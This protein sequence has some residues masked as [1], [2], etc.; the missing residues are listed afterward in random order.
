MRKDRA[1]SPPP[2]A[3]FIISIVARSE[4][5]RTVAG[6]MDEWYSEIARLEGA[7][8][9]SRWYWGQVAAALPEF[10]RLSFYWRTV[11]LKN[12]LRSAGRDLRRQKMFSL[13][14]I[15]GLAVGL[16]CVWLI[17]LY[18]RFETSFDRFHADA[19]RIYRVVIED[20]QNTYQK[21]NKFAVT[22]APL[23]P[24][25]ER[26]CP[27]VAAGTR[28]ANSSRKL[29][30][31]GERSFYEDG[32]HG[33]ENFF[34]MFSFPLVRGEADRSLAEPNTIVISERL[35]RKLFGTDDSL[36]RTVNEEGTTDY[37]VTGVF[38]DVPENSH[39]QFDFVTSFVTLGAGGRRSM[40]RWDE[41]S[42]FTY[43]KLRPETSPGAFTEKMRAV[44]SA[45]AGEEEAAT[46]TPFLLPL[47]GVH[48]ATEFNFGNGPTTDRRLTVLFSLIA[49]FVLLLACI[50][51]MNLATAR[52]AQ[53]SREVGIRRVV[54]AER[55]QLVRQFLVESL[56]VSGLAVILS[57]VLL[58]FV[59]P[60]FNR[61]VER[62]LSLRLVDGTVLFAA[63]SGAVVLLGF[64]TGGY[65]AVF[66]SSLR[67]ARIQR[68]GIGR[69]FG[70]SRVRNALIVF[71]FAVS[72]VLLSSTAIVARQMHFIRTK[73]VG[74][75]RE[76][77]LTV[78]GRDT[79]FRQNLTTLKTELLRSPAVAGV[80][81]GSTPMDNQG[82]GWMTGIGEDGSEFKFTCWKA[83]VDHDFLDVFDVKLL[84]GRFLSP[85][86]PTDQGG[87]V[88]VN[89]AAVRAAGWKDPLGREVSLHE[90]KKA[91]VVGVVKDY[92]FWSLHQKIE[93]MV[94][95]L[96]PGQAQF[97]SIKIK[98]GGIAAVME[99]VRKAYD[100][101]KALHPFEFQY[102][103]LDDR[104]DRLYR[105]DRK[106]GTIFAL[107]AGL[108]VFIACLGMFGLAAFTAEQ[109]AREISIRKVLGAT[110]GS[111]AVFLSRHFLRWVV[112]ANLIA[113]PVA[114]FLMGTWVRGFHYRAPVSPGL[115]VLAGA[116][117]VAL[118]LLAVSVQ[119]AKAART[120]PAERLRRE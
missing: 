10:L 2:L 71:Q 99:L 65:P 12:D 106:F 48:F 105:N 72:V 76:Q 37:K 38:R 103:F 98:P 116:A 45:H 60:S 67:P 91:K 109:K 22:Q 97:I 70:A 89:E 82:G 61:F 112:L 66:L 81:V 6:D 108:S 58:A 110:A 43:V 86:F 32:I 77:I 73:D 53:R 8:R 95:A 83:Y 63:L 35:A 78:R 85:E 90:L 18:V 29:L 34:R 80:S 20:H 14:K 21:S 64:L 100:A 52:F 88:L 59:L 92:H 107:F 68:G 13:I 120:S 15:G 111:I 26:E 24:T 69:G 84:R 1:G 104:F 115:F 57:L 25:L 93:P 23:A 50:N 46:R 33:D 62:S 54:G 30:R 11:M 4:E 40:D 51:Y 96:D 101:S 9:A 16:A 74:Y 39:L 55:W 118:A 28:L 49:A 113:W 114:Y 17:L 5:K 7:R 3:R 119:T 94:L 42:F 75:D 36:G 27:E 117:A 102:E 79:S 41:Y 47:T 56:L 87:A 31:V 19:D 44:V